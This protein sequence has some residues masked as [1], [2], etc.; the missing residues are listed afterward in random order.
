MP[1]KLPASSTL[2]PWQPVAQTL[3]CWRQ[4]GL[5]AARSFWNAGPRQASLQADGR[6]IGL[7]FELEQRLIQVPGPRLLVDGVWFCRPPGGITRV[8][9]QIL[10]CWTLPG[11][12][13]A[14]APVRLIDRNSHLALTD[15]FDSVAAETVDPLDS[16]A[17]AALAA[18]NL[19]HAQAWGATVFLS[20]WISSC[21]RLPGQAVPELSL[22]HDCLPERSQMPAELSHL[23]R[24][25][26]LGAARQVAVSAATAEDLEGLLKRPGGSV[27]W[28]H[29]TASAVFAQTLAEPSSER[30]WRGLQRKVG[31]QQPFVLLPATSGIGSYK[32]PELVAAA[33][34]AIPE[35]RL[36]LSGVG[37]DQRRAELVEA[38]PVLVDRCLGVGF[39]ELELA[40]AYRHALAVVMPSRVEGFGLPAVE[41]AAAGGCLIVADARGLREAAGEFGL[42]VH[43]DRPAELEHLLRLLLHDPS[44]CWLDVLLQ[45]RRQRRLERCCPDLLGLAL[46]AAARDL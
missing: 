40:L 28:C 38:F 30:V 44:R 1:S 24:R 5:D 35:L 36:V 27:L 39:S 6:L 7:G 12:I 45:Q 42:R 29:S 2:G 37:A 26:L 22:V 4:D 3:A 17:V 11:L 9:E 32:N 43:P 33:V 10:Q 31:L 8:W 20:S 14:Q 41:A 21:A 23:R 15:R 46:L 13:T 16:A 25:W 19:T 34:A 18:D